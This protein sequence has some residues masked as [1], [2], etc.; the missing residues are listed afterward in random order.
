LKVGFDI[1]GVMYDFAESLRQYMRYFGY[2]KKYKMCEG[3]VSEWYFYRHWG[4][5]DSEFVNHCHKGV[6]AGFVF[7]HGGA[8]DNSPDAVRFVKDLGHSVHIIT[9]RSFGSTPERSHFATKQWLYLNDIPYDTLDFSADKT[10]RETDM[11]IED[12]LENYDALVAA[13]VDCYLVNRPWNMVPGD[14]R[15]RIKSIQE[16]ATIIGNL[17]V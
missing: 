8:R 3:E 13:G 14:N 9:D 7:S 10:C 15:K 1:D 16:Y 5:T 17:S 6:D 2:D 11:F 12:K 4:M